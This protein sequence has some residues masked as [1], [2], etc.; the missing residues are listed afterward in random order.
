M[1]LR[2]KLKRVSQPVPPDSVLQRLQ[3]DEAFAK[4]DFRQ[5]LG[6]DPDALDASKFIGRAPEQVDD[7]IRDVVQPIRAKYPDDES[8]ESADLHV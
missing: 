4:V 8:L 6:G 1:A 3:A 5:T 7:F 2:Q